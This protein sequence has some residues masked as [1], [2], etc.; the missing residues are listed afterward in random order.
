MRDGRIQPALP[1]EQPDGRTGSS[2]AKR[3]ASCAAWASGRRRALARQPQHDA[4]V[5]HARVRRRS[6]HLGARSVLP[7]PRRREPVRRRRLVLPL[8]GRGEPRPDDRGAGAA[9]R[10]ITSSE[11][12]LMKARSFSHS[13]ITVS[14]FNRAVQFYWEVFGCPAGRGRRQR[15]R[16]ASA[17]FFGVEGESRSCKIGWIRMPGRGGPR[18]LRLQAAAAAGGRS[19]GTA[20]A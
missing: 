17:T 12:D 3:S 13:G 9:G 14:D 5:R 10:P 15:P 11:N 6:A 20:S 8:V 2:C 18:D 19:P 4:P 1:S 7:H 16:I